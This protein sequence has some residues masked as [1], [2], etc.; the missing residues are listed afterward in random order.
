MINSKPSSKMTKNQ[1]LINVII[2]ASI[3]WLLW[4]LLTIP[5]SIYLVPMV[6]NKRLPF[7]LIHIYP[8]TVFVVTGVVVGILS[9][10]KINISIL[11]TFFAILITLMIHKP[12]NE[13]ILAFINLMTFT[14]L[15]AI[16]IGGL[17]GRKIKE[18]KDFGSSETKN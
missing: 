11:V 12:H 9:K 2:T 3:G 16:A 15:C 10:V 14:W 5:Y 1:Q 18:W 6:L 17:I 13:N 7:Y 4:T 8:S